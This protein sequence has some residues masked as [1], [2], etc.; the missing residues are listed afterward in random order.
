MCR[1]HSWYEQKTHAVSAI[2]F[3]FRLQSYFF[4]GIFFI[5][6]PTL[7]KFHQI[8]TFIPT[9]YSKC[10]IYLDFLLFFCDY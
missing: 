1:L 2:P 6:R 10:H 4:V 8:I 7:M 9:F 3:T 5:I